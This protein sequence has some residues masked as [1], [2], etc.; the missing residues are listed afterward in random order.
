MKKYMLICFALVFLGRMAS[1]QSN[2]I[3]ARSGFFWG[4]AA[5]VSSIQLST[6]TFGKHHETNLSFPNFKFGRMLSPRSVLFVYLPG[7]IYRSSDLGRPRD[8][9][10]EGIIPSFQYW[11]KERWWIAAGAGLALDA[12]AFYDIKDESERKFYFGGAALL[13]SGFEVYR[14][15]NFA[16]DIQARYHIGYSNIPND[17]RKGNAL[18]VLVGVNF[19]NYRTR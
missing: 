18:T 3:P 9:G 15:G 2:E 14:K 17:T 8:R 16:L 13:S 10:F 11:V 12:P 5:G 1:A 4:A 7:T 19:S 6:N